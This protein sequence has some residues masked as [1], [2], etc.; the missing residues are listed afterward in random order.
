MFLDIGNINDFNDNVE[1]FDINKGFMLGNMFKNEYDGY[2]G[3]KP[4]MLH[5]NNEK[6][7]L[8]LCIYEYDFALND[9]NLY[10]DLY[11]DNK[12]M[13]N[14][15]KKVNEERKYYIDLYESRYGPLELDKCDYNSYEWYK[16]PWPFEGVDINV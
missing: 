16:G 9:L 12:K 11:P 3:Y 8:L 14:L 7:K 2:K 6:D 15:L 4:S 5:A 13:Y 10:L 1:L